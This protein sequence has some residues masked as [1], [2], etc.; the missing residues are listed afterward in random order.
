MRLPSSL[1]TRLLA[2]TVISIHDMP[3]RQNLVRTPFRS[4]LV[5]GK[6]TKGDNGEGGPFLYRKNRTGVHVHSWLHLLRFFFRFFYDNFIATKLHINAVNLRETGK[7]AV[8]T[9]ATDGI[10]KAYAE[11]LAKKGLKIVLISRT[12]SKLDDVAKEIE[13]KYN[14]ETK[15]IAANFTNTTVIYSEID[16]QLTGLDIGVLVNNVGMSYPPPRVL[17]RPEEQRRS[18]REYNQL[19]HSVRDQYV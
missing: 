16:K 10:G 4:A 9:G 11:L 5:E 17:P 6:A 3:V 7:W 8:V 2:Q 18:I 12:Q 15:T 19:Q 14:V 1:L 13:Q